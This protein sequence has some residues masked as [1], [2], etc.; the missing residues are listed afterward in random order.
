MARK[1]VFILILIGV[2]ALF[3]VL[4]IR[5]SSNK[6]LP[7]SGSEYISLNPI[8]STPGNVQITLFPTEEDPDS[9]RVS[10]SPVPGATS[11]RVYTA[12]AVP[13][14]SLL[15]PHVEPLM[16]P[17]GT[18]K[19]EYRYDKHPIFGDIFT[20]KLHNDSNPLYMHSYG[21]PGSG[22]TAK[23]SAFEPAQGGRFEGCSYIYPLNGERDRFFTVTAVRP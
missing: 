8:F 5:P 1:I 18:V 10:W 9:V 16:L 6:I 4:S 2:A 12:I 22:T 23:F 20:R 14:S 19:W 3:G 21:G 13:D 7:L 11:Y 15:I 17:D